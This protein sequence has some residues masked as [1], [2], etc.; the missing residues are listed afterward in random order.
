MD[1]D[2]LRRQQLFLAAV[3]VPALLLAAFAVLRPRAPETPVYSLGD[4]IDLRTLDVNRASAAQLEALPGIGPALAG[5]IL[6]D[7]ERRGP[8]ASA[9]D[10]G[11]V[12]G[13]GP[14]T[15]R[16]IEPYLI[17]RTAQE[18]GTR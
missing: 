10:L 14:V 11:R 7:R 2:A 13:I 15:L 6:E 8:F 17:F 12:R 5:R 3:T 9:A 16:K 1:G 18:E 4:S